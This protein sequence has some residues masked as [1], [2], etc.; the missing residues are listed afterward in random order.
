MGRGIRAATRSLG[1]PVVMAL[2]RLGVVVL[3]IEVLFYVMLT[4]YF[5]SLHREHLEEEWDAAHPGRAGNTP[6][7]RAQVEAGMLQYR[8]S[9]RARLVALVLVLPFVVIMGIIYAV[10][11]D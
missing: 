5:R 2:L 6:E 8:K 4:I 7:R 11:Y 9:L 10:N 3:V 1:W